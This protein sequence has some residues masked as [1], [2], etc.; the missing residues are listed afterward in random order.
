MSERSVPKRRYTDEFKVEAVRLG[1]S[2]GQHEAARRLGVPVATLG[3]WI[4]GARDGVNPSDTHATTATRT[5]RPMN[6]LEAENS[7]LRKEL[8]SAKLDIEILSKAT[9]YFAKGSR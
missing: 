7:R 3:N 6:E 9:A 5:T 1:E 8:A 2:V 4:R